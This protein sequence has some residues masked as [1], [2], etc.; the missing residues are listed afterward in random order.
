[1]VLSSHRFLGDDENGGECSL[2]ASVDPKAM[3]FRL[4]HEAGEYGSVNDFDGR[5]RLQ[6]TVYLLTVFGAP[7][8]Y[9]WCWYHRGPY[10]PELHRDLLE[11]QSMRSAVAKEAESIGI[12]AKAAEKLLK[13]R[14]LL[15]NHPS[16]ISKT[17]WCELLASVAFL[18]RRQR[19]EGEIVK[20]FSLLGYSTSQVRK[21]L[22]L[23]H[24][25]LGI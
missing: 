25:Q 14:T 2:E 7:F 21:A 12:G 24:S 11:I 23:L 4:L 19:P 6:K 13:L 20:R 1:M 17:H 9:S 16:K 15:R 8:S 10:S 22:A 18:V 5:L 3:L